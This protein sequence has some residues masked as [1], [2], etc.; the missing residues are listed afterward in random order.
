M[1]TVTRPSAGQ[2]HPE[3]AACVATATD[4]E[5]DTFYIQARVSSVSLPMPLELYTNSQSWGGGNEK[6]PGVSKCCGR[7]GLERHRLRDCTINLLC[8][9]GKVTYP[10]WT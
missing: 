7:G 8:N 1:R 10:L 3:G 5:Q 9:F 6:W 4:Q 2:G